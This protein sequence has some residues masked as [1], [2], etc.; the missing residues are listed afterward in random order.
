VEVVEFTKEVSENLRREFLS[1]SSLDQLGEEVSLIDSL[2]LLHTWELLSF[3]SLLLLLLALLLFTLLLLDSSQQ[4]HVVKLDLDQLINLNLEIL[5]NVRENLLSSEISVIF[6]IKVSLLVLIRP[7]FVIVFTELI[8]LLNN[9]RRTSHDNIRLLIIISL[10]LLAFTGLLSLAL[11]LLILCFLLSSFF[12][13]KFLEL[14]LFRSKWN[15][16]LLLSIESFEISRR[17]HSVHAHLISDPISSLFHHLLFDVMA[18]IVLNLLLQRVKVFHQIILVLHLDCL[19]RV[20]LVLC[21]LEWIIKFLFLSLR[22]RC[23]SEKNELI[24]TH[25]LDLF[26]R[27][28]TSEELLDLLDGVVLCGLFLPHSVLHLLLVTFNHNLLLDDQVSVT[29][30][31]PSII[32]LNVSDCGVDV[33]VKSEW[34]VNNLLFRFSGVHLLLEK[35]V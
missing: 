7:L 19:S 27:E 4:S 10:L 31:P 35:I 17:L 30:L 8:K 24:L 33:H 20:L 9:F 16:N 32:L 18:F 3:A 34:I 22:L 11:L 2:D 15:L 1:N 26:S 21:F 12:F 13:F 6:L 25:L 14:F 28:N 29:I 5:L 23:H